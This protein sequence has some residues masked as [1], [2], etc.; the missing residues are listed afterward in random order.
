VITISPYDLIRIARAAELSTAEAIA[1]YTLRRGSLLRFNADGNCA[2]LDRVRCTIHNG[3]PLACRL[4]PLGL[5]HDSN[6]SRFIVLDPAPGSEGAG[7]N[8]STVAEFLEGQGVAPYFEA[9]DLYAALIERFRVRIIAITDFDKIELA[10]FRRRAIREA[11]AES[12]YDSNPLIDALFD[13]DSSCAG[14]VLIDLPLSSHIEVIS[15]LIAREPDPFRVA[16]ASAM[17][18][19][20][21]GYRPDAALVAPLTEHT[22]SVPHPK[23]P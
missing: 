23:R 11:L 20:S 6:D 14:R 22:S 18:A 15:D 17:H 21:L 1:C 8:D 7:G 5:E 16:S 12:N 3:R 10:D 19:L 2:A 4:Y 13:A 9:I